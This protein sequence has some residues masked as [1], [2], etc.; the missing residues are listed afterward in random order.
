MDP[1]DAAVNS[2]KFLS[3]E[4][5]EKANSGHPG[6]P[7]ALAGI[8]TDIFTRYLRYNPKDP[9]WLNRDRFVLSCGHASMLLYSTLHL[10]GYA[11][12]REDL[13]QFRQWGS[14]TPGHPEYGHTQG[15]ETTT[16]PLGQGLSTSVG[17]ALSSKLLGARVNEGGE[18]LIDYRVFALASDGDLM[19]GVASE[20]SSLAGHW[21]LD[22]LI[23]VYDCNNITIDGKADVAF[24]E[25]VRKRYEAYGW[26]VWQ[27]DGHDPAQVRQALDEAT[28]G[29]SRP[30][31]IIAK[32][33]IAI[34]SPT[35]QDTSAAHGSPLG[36]QELDQAREAAGWPVEPKFYVPDEAYTLF[37]K[38]VE[39]VRGQYDAWN[40]SVAGLKGERLAKWQALTDQTPPAQLLQSLVAATDEQTT[41]TRASGSKVL[42]AAAQLS[43][44][45][46]SGSADLNA[47]TKTDLKDGGYVSA[48]N[49]A[50]RNLRYGVRE[51]AMAA[52]ANGLC[53]GGFIPVTSTFL[54]FSDYMRP[55]IRLA[56]MMKLQC[57]FVFTHDSFYVGED[58]PT[59]QPIEQLTSLRLI[60]NLD[61]M[62]PA[63]S[64][65]CAGAWAHALVRMD[66]PT[67]IALTR[68][69]LPALSR[70]AS[71]D[72]AQLLKGGYVVSECDDPTLVLIATGSEVSLA[73]DTKPLL[74]K[75][76]QRVRVVSIPCLELFQRQ[77]EAYRDSVLGSARRVSIEAGV[78]A[79]WGS[80]IGSDG[81]AIGM[82]DFGASAPAETLAEQF[83]FVPERVAQAVARRL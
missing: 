33:H 20:A 82:D 59:H 55:S 30:K 2:I 11:V 41:A 62:R 53:L 63:D 80:L 83:G 77:D 25:D 78:T 47:S 49:Y 68:Q 29:G 56:A 70:P 79:G 45:L 46:V 57:A 36:R 24:T 67:V 44:R 23:V 48:G 10:A 28:S 26:Q 69:N 34:G 31:L 8:T 76:G 60:P 75:Q 81:I 5:V 52:I 58:G 21:E 9:Q 40:R 51:H 6:T 16:G 13:E 38:R 14:K 66:G 32:T 18:P 37:R 3:A 64:L 19:E 12:S 61:V 73:C 42:Q 22:N 1:F 71:F 17:L 4:A 43:T 65:E 54:I 35:K 50:G 74:E 27:V 72:P 39:E 15:V 7:M